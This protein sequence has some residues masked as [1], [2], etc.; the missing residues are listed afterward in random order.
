MS[1]I[2]FGI[3]LGT[4]NS[5]IAKYNNG[6]VEVFKNPVGHKE[7]L[8]SVVA[9]KKERILIGDKAKEYTE[10]DPQNVFASFKRKMGTGES[11]YV[12]S[13][14]Q[15]ITPIEL[16]AHV[17]KE[18]KNFIYTDEKPTSIVITIPASF[19]TIQSNATK[20]AGYQAGFSEVLLLQEPIAA[21]LAFANK[22]NN[23]DIAGKWL[24]YDLGGGTFDVALVTFEDGEMRVKDHEGDNFL[25]GVDFDKLIIER[26]IVPHLLKVG[27]FNNLL[28]EL[29]Q[30][31]G[32]YNKEYAVMMVKAE[33]AK[34]L[35]SNHD[36]ADIEFE[37]EDDHGVQH[38]IYF[39]IKRN[40]FEE[41]IGEQI[42]HTIR[43]LL[44]I[45]DKNELEAKDI[46]EVILI[47]GSTYIPLVRH[48]IAE[49]LK[50]KVNS[51]TDPT[52]AVAIGAA[53]YAGSKTKQT[54]ANTETNVLSSANELEVKAAFQKITKDSEEYFV[55]NITGS[56]EQSTYRIT[57]ND[58]G[59]DTG[60]KALTE[61]ISEVL[62]LLPN[63]TNSFTLKFFDKNNN[64][65]AS[66]LS[67]FEIVHGKFSV[68]GQPLPNDICIEIDDIDN[69]VTKCEVLFEKNTIL[70][71]KKTIIKEVTRTIQ[72]G[73]KD[74]LIINVL[75][76]DKYAIPSSN[77]PL[78]VIEIK[79]SLINSDIIKGSDIE[80]RFEMT[81]SRDLKVRATLLSNDQEFDEVFSPSLRSV[82]IPKLIDEVKDLNKKALRDIEEYEASEQ[83][84]L[85]E[86]A[87]HI[88]YDFDEILNKLQSLSES[89]VTDERYQLEEKKRKLSQQLDSLGK[90]QKIIAAKEE[91][92]EVK[93]YCDQW[94]Q[95]ESDALK[96]K[97]NQILAKEKS[98]LASG[99]VY[100]I[101]NK[102]QEILEFTWIHVR[103][104]K[105]EVLVGYYMYYS[106]KPIEEFIDQRKQK[107]YLE[108]GEKALERQ[109][110]TELHSITNLIWNNWIH[111]DKDK[112]KDLRGTGIG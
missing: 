89:D 99:S 32:K 57:R 34:V 91:Y 94:M 12:P 25:G 70:P 3:D 81:E 31:N 78:G 2:N 55:A 83:Y 40:E 9:F 87:V 4:T 102:M 47:G 24:V 43:L 100:I 108:M 41:I 92:F 39:S 29:K 27:T 37:I 19:D 7:T 26:L 36:S 51:S 11:F 18:L 106:Q 64:R 90:N 62:Q 67:D 23:E 33:E 52:T 49:E 111:K 112:N 54:L 46:E 75:E 68:F 21:S 95:D 20:E 101:K 93:A 109:N 60:L 17:L 88:Q 105:P 107:G 103:S 45:M 76:G 35:L 98:F 79:G 66:N 44:K 59:F 61:R 15:N 63:T 84:E 30:S 5:L 82:S 110:Y 16:S 97:Y 104:K 73:S 10:K 65:I 53:Y 58:G 28:N 77:F 50:I 42:D 22:R 74:Q 72:K 56:F 38:D 86:A 85:A 14:S 48:K 96:L 6:N 71:L 80:I 1:T 8:P 69:G 13:I